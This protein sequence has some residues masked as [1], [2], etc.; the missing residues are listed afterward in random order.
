MVTTNILQT[1]NY[2]HGKNSRW[3]YTPYR[4]RTSQCNMRVGIRADRGDKASAV[5]ARC[6][7]HERQLKMKTQTHRNLLLRSGLTL[8]LVLAV[9]SPVQSQS[10]EPAEGKEMTE[11]C[12]AMMGK[13]KMMMAD[14]KAQDAELTEQLAKMNSAPDDKKVGMMAGV[15]TRMAEQ[16]MATNASMASMRDGMMQHMMEHMKMGGESMGS[17]P[18]MMGMDEKSEGKHSEHHEKPE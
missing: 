3:G 8:A 14:M 6:A 15:V 17:C 13:K 7:K 9:F 2:N 5:T 18:M 11:H 16:R 12:Q 10:A 4:S 1:T